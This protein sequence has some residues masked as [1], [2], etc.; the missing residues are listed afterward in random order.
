MS[1]LNRLVLLWQNVWKRSS[2]GNM[3][4]HVPVLEE[5]YNVS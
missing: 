2:E 1:F 4:T 5:Q 3:F